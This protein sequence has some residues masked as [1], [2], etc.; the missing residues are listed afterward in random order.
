MAGRSVGA[1]GLPDLKLVISSLHTYFSFV[2]GDRSKDATKKAALLHLA[3]LSWLLLPPHAAE[4]VGHFGDALGRLRLRLRNNDGHAQLRR[5]A[6][7]SV[8]RH[9]PED[10][11]AQHPADFL[12]LD[13]AGLVCRIDY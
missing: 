1:W 12:R 7:V 3:G 4:G 2:F 13:V 8:V 11:A 5:R 9:V 10:V 6:D